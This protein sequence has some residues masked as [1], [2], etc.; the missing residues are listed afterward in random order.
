MGVAKEGRGGGGV[1]TFVNA[2]VHLVVH[3]ELLLRTQID[4]GLKV[5]L[6][7]DKFDLEGR[8]GRGRERGKE[9]HIRSLFESSH[10]HTLPPSLPPSP[11]THILRRGLA[12]VPRPINPPRLNA[13]AL[14]RGQITN[15]LHFLQFDFPGGECCG[16]G[17]CGGGGG[18]VGRG[19]GGGDG[20]GGVAC[21]QKGWGVERK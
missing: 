17:C 9:L 15:V 2:A 16:C 7:P 5:D 4:E 3:P 10:S 1:H 11:P 20:G 19:G 18:G 8:G 6:F 21:L 14:H 13:R 12:Q